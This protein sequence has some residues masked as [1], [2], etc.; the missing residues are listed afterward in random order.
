MDEIT[1]RS[2]V[3]SLHCPLFPSTEGIVNKDTMLKMKE[4]NTWAIG[5]FLPS[6]LP[7]SPFNRYFLWNQIFDMAGVA[8]QGQMSHNKVN[9]KAVDQRVDNA[10]KDGVD[11][12]EYKA[13]YQDNAAV[14]NLSDLS[15]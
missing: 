1:D 14:Q 3:I 6:F 5:R 7:F 8:V 11:F 13:G 15:D 12:P 2:D 4:G 9:D 10:V